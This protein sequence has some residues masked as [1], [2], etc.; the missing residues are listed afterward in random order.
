ML[1]FRID[2]RI[3]ILKTKYK[4]ADWCYSYVEHLTRQ[5]HDRTWKPKYNRGQLFRPGW[6]SSTRCSSKKDRKISA[7][8]N[9][10]P[11]CAWWWPQ[12]SSNSNVCQC[13]LT[14]FVTIF[15]W[16]RIFYRSYVLQQHF[17]SRSRSFAPCSLII[18]HFYF[19]LFY[20]MCFCF[21]FSAIRISL[22]FLLF[23]FKY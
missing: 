11:N 2:R 13:L 22:P 9:C 19:I 10:L 1:M 17:R 16:L 4:Q 15:G 3:I 21:C 8:A 20:F 14:L 12:M 6:V 5:W 18:L 7:N 23:H